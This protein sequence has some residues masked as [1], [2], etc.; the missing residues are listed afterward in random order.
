MSRLSV[1]F[2]TLKVNLEF[3]KQYQLF[4]LNI[5][6]HKPALN[7]IELYNKW[8]DAY[9]PCVGIQVNPRSPFGEL[10]EVYQLV[11]QLDG[12]YVRQDELKHLLRHCRVL[13]AAQQ[14]Q[15]VEAIV[16]FLRLIEQAELNPE[17]LVE[18]QRLEDWWRLFPEGQEW[19]VLEW[20]CSLG[21][22]VPYSRDGDR[23]WSRVVHGRTPEASEHPREGVQHCRKE[24][25]EVWGDAISA[26]HAAA[27]FAGAWNRSGAIGPCMDTPDCEN[28]FLQKQCC[29]KQNDQ[30]GKMSTTDL[31]RKEHWDQFEDIDLIVSILSLEG[32][33]KGALG[34][35]GELDALKSLDRNKLIEL[36]KHVD[37]H[38][39]LPTKLSQLKEICRRY[40]EKRLKPS[41]QYR[42]SGDIFE[43]L[44][45]QFREAPQEQFLVVLLDNKHRVLEE[46]NVTQGLLNKS[47][48]HPREVFARAV[49]A[50][51]A[52]LVCVHNHPSGDPEPSPEDHRITERLVESGKLIGIQVLDHVVIGRDRYFSFADKGLL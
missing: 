28:C 10:R 50:R 3:N 39:D 30:S 51:A 43:H 46:V 23:A 11:E 22:E 45:E 20:L 5:G 48:V 9:L 26:D 14:E 29:W 35:L 13:T 8:L 44:R 12:Y 34:E 27:M 38:S 6:Y 18:E 7:R 2:Q 33:G 4:I 42:S 1:F 47:L 37:A 21:L 49:E 17:R 25:A 52:A 24:G 32:E 31:V 40:A 16:R 15:L 41:T 19:G 36:Q